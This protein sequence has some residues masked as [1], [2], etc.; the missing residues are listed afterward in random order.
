MI[1]RLA[2]PGPRT[3]DSNGCIGNSPRIFITREQSLCHMDP[4]RFPQIPSGF[5][6]LAPAILLF[7]T[8]S[9]SSTIETGSKNG[10][11]GPI[12]ST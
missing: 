7:V 5:R 9:V 10:A 1:S 2:D 11:T 12:R 3:G 8:T 6:D 4:S